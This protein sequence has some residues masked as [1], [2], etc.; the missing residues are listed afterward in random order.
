MGNAGWLIQAE[1]LLIGIDLDLS[2]SN[3]IWRAPID[4][5]TLAPELDLVLATHGR[6][7]WIMDDVTA[8]Q[9]LTDEVLES[10]VHLFDQSGSRL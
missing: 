8:L 4:A 7:I 5:R 10:D 6:S 3:R 9:S 2:G 1:G